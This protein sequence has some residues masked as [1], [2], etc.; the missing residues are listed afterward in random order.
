MEI[1]TAKEADPSRDWLNPHQHYLTT[2]RAKAKVLHWFK[3]QDYD[4]N[5]QDGKEII[6]REIKKL[7]L[8]SFLTM[9]LQSNCILK[10]A[11]TCWRH[12]PR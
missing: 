7:S 11:T 5:L 4:R 9:N 1:L 8:L 2:S 6:E 12:W 10:K 3:Q